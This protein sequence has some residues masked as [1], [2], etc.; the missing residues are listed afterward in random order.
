MVP[1]EAIQEPQ[2]LPEI[3]LNAELVVEEEVEEELQQGLEELEVPEQQWA[4][5]EV[6]EVLVLQPEVPAELVEL[7]K[8]SFI[9][10][11]C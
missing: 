8:F 7:D 6:E 3:L 5:V 9:L 4:E 2:E 11:N 1:P 10:G